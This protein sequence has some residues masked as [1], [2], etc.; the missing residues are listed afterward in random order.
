MTANKSYSFNSL[1]TLV[2]PIRLVL[3]WQFLS[4][5]LRRVVNDPEKLDPSSLAYM[6]HAFNHFLPHALFI[7]PMIEYLVIHQQLL[8]TFL[9]TFTIIEGLV[10]IALLLGLFTRLSSIGATL[11]SFGILIGSGWLGSTCVDEWQIGIAGIASGL[12]V[13]TLGAGYLSLDNIIFK[14]NKSS[15]IKYVTSND[16]NW[17]DS[18]IKLWSYIFTFITMLVTLYTYQA[19]HGGL[20]GKLFNLSKNPKI[21]ILDANI[22]KDGT[23]TMTLYRTDGPDTY[24]AFITQVELLDKDN[25][26]LETFQPNNTNVQ[27]NDIKNFYFNKTLPNSY[28]LVVPL[29]AKSEIKFISKKK[30]FL[31]KGIYQIEVS[32]VSGLK[33]A[34]KIIFNE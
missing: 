23:L 17:T 2:T 26:C 14:S 19:F 11:L 7:K 34:K 5:F 8:Y 12:V 6:G 28:S 13:F 9:I 31:Q 25:N 21:E 18:K 3:G 30:L 10:G 24:G 29:G 15:F 4:A 20:Y 27:G 16:I 1:A 32:D 33:W 22:K